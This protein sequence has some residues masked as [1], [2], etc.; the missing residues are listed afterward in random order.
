MSIGIACTA[1]WPP[2]ALAPYTLACP[3]VLLLGG[4]LDL[5]YGE[6]NGSVSAAVR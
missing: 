5:E 1:P 4:A 6:E 3:E 2:C